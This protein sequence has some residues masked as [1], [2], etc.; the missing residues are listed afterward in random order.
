M[1]LCCIDGGVLEGYVVVFDD[2]I[3]LVSVQRMAVWGDV[4]CC[5][6][7]EIKNSLILIQ[8][9]VEWIKCKFCVQVGDDVEVLDQ[10]IDVIVC[11]TND[12]C[13][14][15]DEFLKF[16]W[17]LEFVLVLN[18]LIKVVVDVIMLQCAGQP[19]V[20]IISDLPDVAILADM[21]AMMILQ[22]LLN[23]IKNVGEVMETYIEK[24]SFD[25]YALQI[26]IVMQ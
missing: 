1:L 10:M 13:C 19:Q 22:V 11:Q 25:G 18:D 3:D 16:A 15:V 26:R 20:K 6:V 14:I 9:L 8:L 23:L 21:D 24:N 4:A 7:H 17:M 5:I 12:L 2:V